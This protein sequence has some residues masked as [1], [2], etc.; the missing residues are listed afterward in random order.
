MKLGDKETAETQSALATQKSMRR[1]REGTDIGAIAK[2]QAEARRADAN[3]KKGMFEQVLDFD[4]KDPIAL[5]GMGQ[6]LNVLGRAH[7]ALAPCRR[8]RWGL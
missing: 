6:A 7:S 8:E 2:E 1:N 5:F 3:R 4:P